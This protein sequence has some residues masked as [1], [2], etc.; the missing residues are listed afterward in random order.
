MIKKI[1]KWVIV[2]AILVIIGIIGN[3]TTDNT[4]KTEEKPKVENKS[5]PKKEKKSNFKCN[6]TGDYE[7]EYNKVLSELYPYGY[8]VHRIADYT[9]YRETDTECLYKTSIKITNEYGAKAN[10]TMYIGTNIDKKKKK[11]TLK[12]IMIDNVYVYGEE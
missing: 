5:K 3:L 1:P 2:V 9:L 12:N 4:T 11:E 10:Y 6:D 7:N 8:K